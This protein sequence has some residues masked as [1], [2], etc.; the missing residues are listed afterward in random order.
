M[1][2]APA[3][4]VLDGRRQIFFTQ[5]NTSQGTTRVAAFDLPNTSATDAWPMFRQN[6]ARTGRVHAD[7]CEMNG[8]SG[9]FCDVPDGTYFTEAVEWMVAESITAGVSPTLFGPDFDLT[10]AQMVTFLWRQG[11][12]PIGYPPH[13]F[14]DVPAGAYY[15][16]A[17]AW[18][19]AEEITTG[20]STSTFSPG[21]IV[22]RAQLVT[23]LW[24]RAGS[25]GGYPD[26][27]FDDVPAGTYFTQAVAWA[28]AEDITGGFSASIFAPHSPVTRAQAAALVWR[29]AGR[30]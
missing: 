7:L 12:E 24:R 15:E 26:P 29:E 5:F 21:T 13:R 28:K 18:A 1:E 8:A 10:R 19:K 22:T 17:V 3:V 6:P 23:L 25:P 20:T 14:G 11:G 4:G 9:S 27:G 16:D 2:N 30:P